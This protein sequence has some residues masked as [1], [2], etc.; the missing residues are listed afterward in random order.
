M[1][2]SRDSVTS[3]LWR[4]MEIAIV[5]RSLTLPRARAYAIFHISLART[6]L[7]L[8]PLAGDEPVLQVW[9]LAIHDKAKVRKQGLIPGKRS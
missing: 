3:S 2:T 9:G 6:F 1:V 7:L 4:N 5:S 8:A